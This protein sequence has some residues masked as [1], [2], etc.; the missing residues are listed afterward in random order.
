MGE[1][2]PDQEGR[3]ANCVGWCTA[4]MWIVPARVEGI[5]SVGGQELTLTQNYQFVQGTLGSRDIAE[6]RLRGSEISF[7]VDGVKYAGT[8]A[9]DRMTVARVGLADAWTAVRR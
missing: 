4:L 7:S 2:R 5:W 9:G 1:W 6:G 3:P 8:V